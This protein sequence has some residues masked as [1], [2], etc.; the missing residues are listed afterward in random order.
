MSQIEVDNI[1]DDDTSSRMEYIEN[2]RS[3]EEHQSSED[4]TKSSKKR[5][6][7]H[8][9]S[10]EGSPSKRLKL[11]NGKS[12]TIIMKD[13]E[14]DLMD[15]DTN[16][17]DNNKEESKKIKVVKSNGYNNFKNELKETYERFIINS[18][19]TNKPRKLAS[20]FSVEL[21]DVMN[22][23]KEH[24]YYI[25]TEGQGQWVLNLLRDYHKKYNGDKSIKSAEA[26]C[27]ITSKDQWVEICANK[28]I[29]DCNNIPNVYKFRT[30]PP[31]VQHKTMIL[32]KE[33]KYPYFTN[34]ECLQNNISIGGLDK[35]ITG[36]KNVLSDSGYTCRTT[37]SF[38]IDKIN[39]T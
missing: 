35:C 15:E 21:H 1:S 12:T 9:N 3:D 27:T 4:L 20:I 36:F 34:F 14:N 11:N 28:F 31:E 18:H 7:E 23:L 5:K 8:D 37:F 2:H 29:K 10:D 17:D 38:D 24:P 25:K 22:V 39:L 26:K 13:N 6:R 33:G 19:N 30:L 32:L 16:V